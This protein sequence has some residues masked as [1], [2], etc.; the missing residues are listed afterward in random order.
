MSEW[1]NYWASII[2]RRNNYLCI[3]DLDVF[4]L[5][6]SF[7]PISNSQLFAFARIRTDTSKM[8]DNLSIAQKGI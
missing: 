2:L 3:K 7:L 1:G 5:W 4:V 6:V 8:F